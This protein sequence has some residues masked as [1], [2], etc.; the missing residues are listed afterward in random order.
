MLLPNI[1]K[2]KNSFCMKISSYV[3]LLLILLQSAL[4]LQQG[5]P[6]QQKII[7]DSDFTFDEIFKVGKFPKDI[8][9]QLRLINVEYFSFDGNLHRGQVLI[10]KDLADD[11]SAIFHLIK[12]KRFPIAKV[13]P[14]HKYGW[15]D[16]S[17]MADNNTPAFNYRY[18]KGTRKL[19]P[20]SLGRAID[21]NP[22]LNPQIK[23]GEIYP[24]GSKYNTK[25]S[26]T[27]TYDSF[28]VKEFKKRGWKW[29][30]SWKRNKDYQHFEKLK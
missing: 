3:F 13:I 27:I 5:S 16:D 18:V 29:G 12:E 19:S 9:N 21:I 10:H 4:S 11:V 24:V 26:G 6:I 30:G 14:M 15:S 7:I 25:V 22:L 20:H 2:N 1:P 23:N 28:I 17:S 8:I